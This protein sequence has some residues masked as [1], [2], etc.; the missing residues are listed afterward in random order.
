M[1]FP[2]IH[3]QLREGQEDPPGLDRFDKVRRLPTKDWP[4]IVMFG[5]GPE[6]LRLRD[7]TL[8]SWAG[9]GYEVLADQTMDLDWSG[10]N[11]GEY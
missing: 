3:V 10:R 6:Q 11:P 8:H 5:S 4:L 1:G 7:E 9:L 2:T